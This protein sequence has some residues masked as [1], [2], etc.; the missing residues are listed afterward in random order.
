MELHG[1]TSFV[2]SVSVLSTG[3]LISS[4]ED[5][6]V[7]IWK[8]SKRSIWIYQFIY[9]FTLPITDGQCI[10]T[11]HQPCISVWCVNALPNDDIVVGGS[12][13]VV[14][15]FTRSQERFADQDTLKVMAILR[16]RSF[17]PIY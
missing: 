11:I 6:S 16:Y 1:H 4:G 13:G 7:R 15:L 14:R 2:Y 10:Q 8:G 17:R 12:D 9:V 3:E 5:R